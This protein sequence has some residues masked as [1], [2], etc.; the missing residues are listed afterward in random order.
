MCG[1]Q[2][3][4]LKKSVG[5][6]NDVQAFFFLSVDLSL[7]SLGLAEYNALVLASQLS[8]AVSRWRAAASRYTTL[9]GVAMLAR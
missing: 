9:L 4:F 3:L 1:R 5:G 6:K 2:E 8:E 7:R